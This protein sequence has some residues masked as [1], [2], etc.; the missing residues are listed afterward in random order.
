MSLEIRPPCI[1]DGLLVALEREI[2]YL[3]YTRPQTVYYCVEPDYRYVYVGVW[4]DGANGAY[5]WFIW[6]PDAPTPLRTSDCGYGCIGVA[7]CCGLVESGVRS[8]RGD[9]DVFLTWGR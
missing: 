4:G 3:Q 8:S 1:P 7:L 6:D 2:R 5:E 9:H